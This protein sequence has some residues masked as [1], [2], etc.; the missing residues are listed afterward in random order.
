MNITSK[1][2][3]IVTGGAGY[4]GSHI[5]KALAAENYTPVTLDNLSGG[6][7]KLVK[8]GPLEVGD[9]NNKIWLTDIFNKYSPLAIIHCAGLI[10]VEES[11]KKPEI[12]FRNNFHATEILLDAMRKAGVKHIIYSSTASV[13]GNVT[14]N[15][16]AEKQITSP[17]NPYAESKLKAENAIHKQP[18][19][20]NDFSAVI[21]RYFNAAGADDKS[22]TGELHNPETHLIPLAIIAALNG[23]EFT[24]YGDGS[25][26]RDYVHVSD[27]ANAHLLALKYSISNNGVQT[28]NIGTGQGFSVIEVV[29]TIEKLSGKTLNLKFKEPRAGDVPKLV[30]DVT[31]ATELMS[32]KPQHS[33]LNNIIKT[34]IAWHQMDSLTINTTL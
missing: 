3:I 5:C 13:Y 12:Y 15:V 20:Q 32:Y 7:E 1:Q 6:F 28:F 21:L 31:K 2:N 34:A 11:T 33:S 17:Q 29:R 8:W 16:I 18:K 10:S 4:I 26:V 19:E 14:E 24:I 22:E 25:V 27:I 23:T 30:A 9:I